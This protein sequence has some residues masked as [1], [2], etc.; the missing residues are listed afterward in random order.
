[1]TDEKADQRVRSGVTAR[2]VDRTE[3]DRPPDLSHLTPGER[4]GLIW[5]LTL[6]AIAMK[7]PEEAKRLVDARLQRD[8]ERVVRRGR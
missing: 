1:M 8:V 5:P 6:A 2:I 4:I 7:D 3:A